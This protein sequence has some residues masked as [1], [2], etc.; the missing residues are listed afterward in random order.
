M[1]TLSI[2]PIPTLRRIENEWYKSELKDSFLNSPN[3]LIFKATY[4]F[5]FFSTYYCLY[6]YL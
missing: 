3:N 5:L 4:L 6:T 1:S 2:I